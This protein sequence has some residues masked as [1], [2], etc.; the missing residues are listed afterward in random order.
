MGEEEVHGG[1]QSGVQPDEPQDDPV[2]QQGDGVEQGEEPKEEHLHPRAERKSQENEIC[3]PC[4]IFHHV[5]AT[6]PG[7]G[8]SSVLC[9]KEQMQI[10]ISY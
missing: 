9:A 3:D 10:W 7:V 6:V 1:V 8:S 5:L 4:L 2:A